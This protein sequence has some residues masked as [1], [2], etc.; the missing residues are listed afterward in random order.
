MSLFHE[1][2]ETEYFWADFIF[3]DD[4]SAV[5][6]IEAAHRC[7]TSGGMGYRFYKGNDCQLN[8]TV[9]D[10]KSGTKWMLD[11][12]EDVKAA[13]GKTARR[14]EYIVASYGAN[15]ALPGYASRC[16]NSQ[17][18]PTEIL[19][20]LQFN[21]MWVLRRETFSLVFF[22]IKDGVLGAGEE[23]GQ[24]QNLRRIVDLARA[25]WSETSPVF[26]WM[27]VSSQLYSEAMEQISKG[28]VP[29]G[30]W[31]SI[32]SEK[33]FTQEIRRRL[34]DSPHLVYDISKDGAVF[35]ENLKC[36]RGKLGYF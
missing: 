33:V 32:N 10:R 20:M 34:E 16:G 7:F 36:R 18:E 13:K 19:F 14:H 24:K 30:A 6:I 8:Y 35:I 21:G 31:F 11:L 3:T 2:E 4:R 9:I 23:E 29:S 22:F 25:L 27:D 12:Y 5:E 28:R 1:I 15:F 17:V 26:C